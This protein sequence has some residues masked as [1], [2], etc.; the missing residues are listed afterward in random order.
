[1]IQLKSIR[2]VF[3]K[4]AAVN[5]VSFEVE[6]GETLVLLGT[7]GCGKTTTL[8]MI[9]RLVEPT[10]GSIYVDGKNIVDQNPQGLRKGI[11]YVLQHTGLFPHYTVQE[12]VSMVPKLLGWKTSDIQLRTEEILD[13]LHLPFKDYGNAYPRELSGG[14]QQRVG[15]ARAL[16][17]RPPML[18][19]DEPFGALDPITRS[20]ITAEFRQL[21]ELTNKTIVLVTHDV[22][23]AFQLGDRICLMDKGQVVQIGTAKDLLTKPANEF[24]RCF[25]KEHHIVLEMQTLKLQDLR[26][27]LPASTMDMNLISADKSLW[28]AL[29]QDD[30]GSLGTSSHSIGTLMLAYSQY[31]IATGE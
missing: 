20:K 6:K 11:G 10:S 2:K 16:A 14:Q 18:L 15:L 1:M 8:R 7:S 17:A 19:M 29:Q 23:E 4:T 30:Q 21:E 28:Q 22:R 13:K 12:N 5:N 27:Y 31:K 9:N 26:K 24:V 3:N 25:F